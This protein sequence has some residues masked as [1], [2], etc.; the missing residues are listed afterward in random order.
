MQQVSTTGTEDL[1]QHNTARYKLAP[2]EDHLT[3]CLCQSTESVLH[4]E[5]RAIDHPCSRCGNYRSV[6]SAHT[7]KDIM[8]FHTSQTSDT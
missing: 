6:V 2:Q 4:K 8:K 5:A 1:A 7:E 3:K